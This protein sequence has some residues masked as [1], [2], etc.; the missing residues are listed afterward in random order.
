MRM[1]VE[2]FAAGILRPEENK[3]GRT[4]REYLKTMAVIEA[5]YLSARTG[6]PESPGKIMQMAQLKPEDVERDGV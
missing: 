4:G 6:M 1:V 2:D 3:P 5:A